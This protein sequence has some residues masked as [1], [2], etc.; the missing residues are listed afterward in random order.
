MGSRYDDIPFEPSDGG[1][2][3]AGIR[4][5]P[6]S[7]DQLA[8]V[9]AVAITSGR[10]FRKVHEWAV[11]D[12]GRWTAMDEPGIA[13]DPDGITD[14]FG[15]VE[16]SNLRD[17]F[18]GPLIPADTCYRMF[19]F[20]KEIDHVMLEVAAPDR[21]AGLYHCAIRDGVLRDVRD[22][23]GVDCYYQVGRAWVREDDHASALFVD[24][25]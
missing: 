13:V 9:R 25:L 2:E 14:R 5:T 11:R 3:K 17:H 7:T 10:S 8:L 1:Q 24:E 4:D 18:E 22:S 20:R 6:L 16:V 23:L 15:L 19:V 21:D 12:R